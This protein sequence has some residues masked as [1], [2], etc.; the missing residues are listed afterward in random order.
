MLGDSVQSEIIRLYFSKLRQ[1]IQE[2]QDTLFQAMENKEDLS[3]S[4]LFFCCR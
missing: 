4:S 2:N 3:K 1:F